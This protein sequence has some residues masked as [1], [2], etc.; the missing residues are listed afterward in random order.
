MLFVVTDRGIAKCIDAKTGELKWEKR[1]GGGPYRASPLA[2]D[3]RI[4][5]LGTKGLTTVVEAAGEFKLLAKNNLDDET[6]ASPIASDGKIFV[7]GRKW[8]Y[9]LGE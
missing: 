4:Y 2:A 3:G 6:F 8:L 5:F 1:L 7:R 9:C